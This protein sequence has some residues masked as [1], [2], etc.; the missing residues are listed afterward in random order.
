MQYYV[1]AGAQAAAAVAQ[2]TS[3]NPNKNWCPGSG[4]KNGSARPRQKMDSF[5]NIPDLK[6][7]GEAALVESRQ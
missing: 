4:D 3:C 5:Q 2:E 1:C 6:R 7:V